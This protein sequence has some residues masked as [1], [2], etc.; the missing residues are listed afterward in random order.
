M[1]AP[2]IVSNVINWLNNYWQ[3]IYLQRKETQV[4]YVPFPKPDDQ[5]IKADKPFN[6]SVAGSNIQSRVNVFLKQKKLY[7]LKK[8]FLCWNFF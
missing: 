3:F 7:L 5:N 2:A 1:G 6:D 8:P 4:V